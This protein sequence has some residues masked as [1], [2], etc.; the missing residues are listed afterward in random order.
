MS[1]YV[2]R[3]ICYPEEPTGYVGRPRHTAM[4]AHMIADTETELHSMAQRI[5]L[6][7]E[8][9]Q[10]DHYDVT[11]SRRELAVRY[12]AVPLDRHPFI[13]ALRRFRQS[14]NHP[15]IARGG[16]NHQ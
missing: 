13:T 6:R 7:R 9:F 14:L 10:G 4:W 8:W 11:P 1:V 16:E 12:G 5:G 2:D 3:A 15:A